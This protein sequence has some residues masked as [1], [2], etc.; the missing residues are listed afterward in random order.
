MCSRGTRLGDSAMRSSQTAPVVDIVLHKAL[1]GGVDVRGVNLLHVTR[2]V[3]QDA[4]ESQKIS[5]A[6]VYSDRSTTQGKLSEIISDQDMTRQT[7]L[8]QDSPG[9]SA[10]PEIIFKQR[11]LHG[12]TKTGIKSTSKLHALHRGMN[13]PEVDAH[14]GS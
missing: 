12:Q 10:H 14:G 3:L 13:L 6:C 11:A 9:S 1:H 8:L 7:Q 5:V 2:D 4:Q